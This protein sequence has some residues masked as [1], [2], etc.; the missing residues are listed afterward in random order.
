MRSGVVGLLPRDYRL[1]DEQVARR[2]RSAGFTG[3]SVVVC[4]SVEPTHD[5]LARLR[6]V[7]DGAGVRVAQLN[8]RYESLVS[9][10]EECRRAGVRVLRE[11]CRWAKWLAAT[12]TYVR[13]GSL[14]PRGPWLPHPANTSP[15]TVER[16]ARSLREVAPA[17]E[18]EGVYL[19]V[20]GHVLSPLETPERVHEVIE[21]VG[22]PAV[23][24]NADPVNFVGRLEDA[25]ASA[26]LLNRMFDLL[27]KHV[28]CAHV[29]DLRVEERRRDLSR[30][31]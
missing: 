22:S 17:A 15:E 25:Y 6:N 16:L 20:E 27:G 26:G 9:A 14:N 1:T 12:N 19:A 7:L 23:R 10:D 5:E 31:T 18:D 30:P 29:K 2:I 4:S 21:A 3:V 24:F 11:S 13:P 28:V 8:A